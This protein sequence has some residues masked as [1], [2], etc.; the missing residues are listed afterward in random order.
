MPEPPRMDRREFTAS[1]GWTPLFDAADDALARHEAAAAHPAWFRL[2]SKGGTDVSG[3][4]CD[5]LMR[6]LGAVERRS[7]RTCQACGAPGRRRDY[8]V[9]CDAHAGRHPYAS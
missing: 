8:L 1:P 4:C 2:K 3:A 6:A 7:R 5:T 9:E